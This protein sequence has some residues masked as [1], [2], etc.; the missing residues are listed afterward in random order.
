MSLDTSTVGTLAAE[1]MERLAEQYSE[2]AE[3]G[4]VAVVAEI[5][6][7]DSTAIYYRCTDGRH[8]IQ[9]GLFDAAKRA[10]IEQIADDDEED[11]DG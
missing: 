5:D 11:D 3:I 8:W 1:L 9:A 10:V 4:I 7:G 2:D 6:C